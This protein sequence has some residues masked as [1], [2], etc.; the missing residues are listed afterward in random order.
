MIDI[1]C[2]IL[3]GIDDGARDIDV[4]IEMAKSAT[5][6]GITHIIA[7]PHYKKRE[8][9]NAKEKILQAVEMVK[10]ELSQ[11]NIP[12]IILP[13]QE[14]RI[15]GELLQDYT[16]GELLSLNNGGKYLFVEF[17]SGHVPRYAEQLLFDIQLNGLTPVIVHP[18]RNSELIENPDLLYKFVKN[19]ACTQITSS[20]VT[21]HFGKKI[22]KFSLQLVEYNLTHFLA[23]DAHNLSNRPFR[24]REAYSVLVKEYGTAAEYYFKENAELLV[25]GKSVIKDTPERIKQKKLFGLFG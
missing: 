5:E 3:P 12:L 18:E 7:T 14:P 15:D 10:K 23:S 9:E 21:G 1:H 24:L 13:G 16:K 4:T 6:E 17:P 19:G 8:Y 22:K 20:S 2:H 25:E 11:Q